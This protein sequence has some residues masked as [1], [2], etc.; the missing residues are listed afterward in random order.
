[1]IKTIAIFRTGGIGDVILS[2][3]SIHIVKEYLPDAK[4]IWFG[5]A[6]TN[7]LIEFIF[8]NIDTYEISGKKSYAE[9][10]SII[11]NSSEKIHCIIDLQHSARTVILGRLSS[12]YFKCKYTSWNKYSIPRSLLVLQSKIRGRTFQFDLFKNEL[13]NRYQAMALCTFRALKKLNLNCNS[14]SEFTP[15]L[16]TTSYQKENAIAIC[17]GAKFSAKILPIDKTEQLIDYAIKEDLAKKLY[18]I[19]DENQKKNATTLMSTFGDK[20]NIVDL[21]GQTTLSQAAEVLQKCN[22]AIVND[23]AL[24]HLS[25]AVGTR[26]LMFFGPTHQKFGY[27][28]YLKGSK[29][30]S[31][32]IGCRPCNK[33]GD[34][35]CR[36]ND[37][38]CSSLLKNESMFHLLTEIKNG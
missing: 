5:R 27:R 13:P 37:F 22:F 9:N 21:T 1:M 12:Q 31:V 35:K 26:V 15:K 8:P 4:I 24:A 32:D 33:N 18:L 11:K 30:L 3:V 29:I 14:K 7:D 28:P 19:G 2:T 34:T 36:Y 17:L 38:A 10:L 16:T 25:E 6:E 20:I 23:S